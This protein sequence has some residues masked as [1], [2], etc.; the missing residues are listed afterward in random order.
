MTK[1]FAIILSVLTV[2]ATVSQAKEQITFTDLS[3][4]VVTVSVPVD[5]LI[6]GEGR[7]LPTLGI[8]DRDNPVKRVVGMMGEFQKYDPATYAQ[9]VDHFPKIRDIPLIGSAGEASF[10][11]EKAFTVRPQVALFGLGSGHGPNDKSKTVIQQLE[12]AGIPVVILDFRMDPLKNTP[13]S[14][15]ILGKLFGKEADALAFNTFYKQRLDYIETKLADVTDRPTVF[16]ETHVGMVP[17]CCRAFGRQ[18]M[19]RFIEW[20]GGINAFGEMIP[21]AVGQLNVEHLLTSQPDVYIGSA[22]G[23]AATF[24][25]FP[26]YITLGVGTSNEM[27]QTTLGNVLA[28]TGVAQLDAVKQGRAHAIWHHFYNTPMNLVAVEVIAKWLHPE[29]FG[30]LQPEQT[31][32][33]YFDRF[34]AVP[35]NGIYWVTKGEF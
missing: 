24:E 22:I 33:T 25:K 34:Q 15:E 7:Y 27:A 16:M 12:A 13:K 6:L 21:G 32:K 2:C 8:L 5:H 14:M 20:A 10:S 9:Y 18:M 31:L 35:L 26:T 3:G 11:I 4:R 29:V 19:G 17:N 1:F 23:S 30:D 28:R